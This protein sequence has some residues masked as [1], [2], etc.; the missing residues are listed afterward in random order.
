MEEINY[1]K[2]V[3]LEHDGVYYIDEVKGA[4]EENKKRAYVYNAIKKIILAYKGGY[5]DDYISSCSYDDLCEILDFMTFMNYDYYELI[6]KIVSKIHMYECD[7]FIDMIK[8]IDERYFDKWIDERSLSDIKMLKKA[9]FT[10][11][12]GSDD[13]D[14]KYVLMEK[15]I[16]KYYK[17]LLKKGVK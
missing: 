11:N 4:Y 14:D 1:K 9:L 10:F 5:V 3:P 15:A 12:F 2:V 13:N 16:D 7:I 8:S 6:G 17:K